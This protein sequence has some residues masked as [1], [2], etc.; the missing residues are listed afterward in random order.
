MYVFIQ[1]TKT[2]AEKFYVSGDCGVF[3]RITQFTDFISELN[4]TNPAYER[5][6]EDYTHNRI[7]V[8]SFSVACKLHNYIL[9]ILE[10]SKF[11]EYTLNNISKRGQSI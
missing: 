3:P 6:K 7:R 5:V 11:N 4:N 8:K 2:L 9:L 1:Y 10:N